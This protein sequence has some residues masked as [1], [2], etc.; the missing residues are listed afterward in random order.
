MTQLQMERYFIGS[1]NPTGWQ[2]IFWIVVKSPNDTPLV[3][4]S[5]AFTVAILSALLSLVLFLFGLAT[6]IAFALHL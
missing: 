3:A 4:V 6:V 5:Q 2:K 1:K